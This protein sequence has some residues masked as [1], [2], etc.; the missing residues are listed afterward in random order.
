MNRPGKR[1]VWAAASAIGAI[2]LFLGLVLLW[3]GPASRPALAEPPATGPLAPLGANETPEPPTTVVPAAQPA[4]FPDLAIESLSLDPPRP[5]PG[6]P[7]TITVVI[8]NIGAVALW[9]GFYTYLYVDPPQRPPSP[10]TPDT[11]YVGWFLGLGPGATFTWSY[12]DYT[13]ETPGCDHVIYAWADR[14]DSI[15]EEN[16]RNNLARLEVCVGGGPTGD[17]YEP[18]DTCDQA[19]LIQTDGQAQEH[20][21]APAGDTDWVK[22]TG[23]GGVEYTITAL[24]VGANADAALSLFAR[25]NLPASFGGSTVIRVTLPTSG[26]YYIKAV[27]HNTGAVNDTAYRISV[28]SASDCSGYYEPNDTRATAGDIAV[29]A[30]AQRH[31]FCRAGDEDWVKFAVRAGNT[32]VVRA[33]AVGARA[34]PTL[35]G[36]FGNDTGTPFSGNPLEFTAPADGFFYVRAANQPPSVYGPGTEYDLAVTASACRPDSF[37]PDNTRAEAKAV[38]VNALPERRNACPAGDRDWVKFTATAGITYTLESMGLGAVSDTIVCLF[39]NIGT[40]IACD[41]EGGANHGS[42][43]TWQASSSGTYYAEIRQADANAAGP[44]TEYEFSIVTGLCRPDLYEPDDTADSARPLP[45]DGSRQARNFCAT[46]DRDWVRLDIPAA[47]WYTIRTTDLAPGSDTLLTLYGAD[48]TAILETNDDFG[49][50]TASQ[51]VYQFSRPGTYYVEI[52]HFNPA[53]YGRSTAYFLAASAGQ[54][55]ATPTPTPGTPTPTPTATATPPPSGIQ[56]LILTNRERLHTI[57]GTGRAGP[58]LD[59]LVELANH[60]AVQ[61]EIIE[62]DGNSAVAAAYATWSTRQTDVD[63]ANQVAAAV[64]GLVMEYL[65]SH[66]TTQYIVLV[67]DDRVIPARRIRDRTSYPESQYT[68]L[69]SNTPVGAA[70]AQDYFLTDDYY[71]DREPTPW[72]G[73]ELYIPDLAIGRLIE[74]PEEIISQIDAFMRSPE[75]TIG[76]ATARALVVGYDFV[77]D[78]ATNIATDLLGQDLGNAHVD[79]ILIGDT[80]TSA[81]FRAKQLNTNPA[82]KL[83]SINGHASHASQGAPV[84]APVT[85]REVISGTSDLTGAL[86]YSVGCHSGLNVPETSNFPLDLAQAFAQKRAN[87][88]G[89]T[90]FGWGSRIGVYLSERLM[91]NY[92]QEL[93]KGTSAAIGKALAA[94]KRRYYQEAEGFEDKDEKVMQQATLYG[95]PMYRINT[96]A[97]LSDDNPFPSARI[98]SPF[99]GGVGAASRDMVPPTSTQAGSGTV[100]IQIGGGEASAAAVGGFQQ[101]TTDW[102]AYFRLDGHTN[103]LASGPIQPRIYANLNPPVGQRLRGAVFTGGRFITTTVDP[104][105]A[106]PMN[107]YT[108]VDREPA[109]AAEGFYPP[110]PFVLHSN[111]TLSTTQATLAV[112]LGQYADGVQRLYTDVQYDVYFSA[113]DDTVGPTVTWIDGFYNTRTEQ[114]TFKVEATDPMTVTRVLIAYSSGAGSWS[115]F[116]LAYNAGTHKWSGTLPGVRGAQYYVQA[117]D[118][119]GNATAVTRKG[120]YFR[121]EDVEVLVSP[122]RKLHLPLVIR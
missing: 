43:L 31:S 99:T 47:G 7:A 84:G 16:E 9:D 33:T 94:A 80:W 18:D 75:I 98:I 59:K 121:L 26:T 2:C 73:A 14:D 13:F 63:A 45:T 82:F 78:V 27:N 113:L 5:A 83:Q 70:I 8:K 93:L 28:S 41:D 35:A 11:A 74:T 58:L 77:Q 76:T 44:A 30:A 119:A 106:A 88:V 12:T 102:G 64:R 53:R 32:Y 91:Q 100:R 38:T 57:Y 1:H 4:A 19:T 68:A 62:V 89:N 42:R 15:R 48:R 25:C 86:I 23:I 108:P 17:Q 120:G 71:A 104:V 97:V 103:T 6:Q 10:T 90:G 60:P 40:Q 20:T 95:F 61:G 37:E 52:R 111:E 67:G 79:S 3:G 96:P 56:T 109:F 107:E 87:Y 39:D 114:A 66:P 117:V 51:L 24:N 101:V 29:G 46:N 116:D 21:F 92:T 69:S 49:P 65:A 110:L 34:T 115:S 50:G 36:A 112:V 105:I 72:Q 55:Q 81:Q 54:P 118:G 85:A 122:Q 22:F